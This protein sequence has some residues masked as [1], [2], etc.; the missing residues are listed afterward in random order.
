MVQPG[1]GSALDTPRTNI[2]DATYLNRQ[3]D[4]ADISQEASF[5]SP[6]KDG[7]LLQQLRNGRSTGISL[8]TPRQRGPLADRRNLPPSI[9]GAEFTPLLKSATRNSIQKQGK[10][11]GA[12]MSDTP[13]LSKIDEDDVTALPRMDGS[14]YSVSRNQSYLDNTLPHVES[15]SVASTPL[16]MQPRR[17]ANKGPLQ[18]GNQLSLREQENVIDRIEKEN[19][20]LKLKIHFLEEAL[21]KAGPGFSEA[22]LKENTELK[23]DKVTMQRE[24]Q[25]YKKHVSTAEKD[26]ET[27]RQE[28]LELQEKTKRR[29]TDETQRLKLEQLQKALEEREANIDNLQR[30]LDQGRNDDDQLERLRDK[31]EDMEADLREKDRQITERDDELDEVRERVV[32][33]EDEAKEAQRRLA[34]LNEMEQQ[35]EELE[36]AKETIQDLQ[37]TLRQLE[38]QIAEVKDTADNAISQRDRAERDLEELQEE[39]A[40]KSVVTKGLSRQIEEKVARLQE[41]LDRSGQEYADVE[42]ELSRANEENERLRAELDETKNGQDEA[43]RGQRLNM[44]RIRELE[45]ELLAVADEKDTL[46]LRHES[47]M[48]ESD[49]LQHEVQ[50]LEG[51]V[52][53]LQ[54]HTADEKEYALE[55]EKDLRQQFEDELERLNNEIS[56]LQAEVRER[57]NLYDNDSEK[58]DVERQTLVSDRERAEERAAGLQRTIDRLRE[59]EGSLSSKE[60]SLQKAM[61]SEMERHKSE[62]AVTARQ[63][64]DLQDALETRASLL[65]KLRNELSTARDELRQVQID[66]QAQVNKVVAMEDEIELLRLKTSAQG[67]PGRMSSAVKESQ[68]LQDQVKKLKADLAS[69]QNS[70]AEA[71]AKCDELQG[72]LRQQ[73]CP[74]NDGLQMDQERLDLRAAKMKLDNEVRRLTDE[75][76]SLK[77]SLAATEKALDDARDNACATEQSLRREIGQLQSKA[78]SVSP[79]KSN[80]QGPLAAHHQRTIRE[81]EQEVGFYRDELSK[82]QSAGADEDDAA[83]NVSSLRRD[84]ATLRQKE[85]DFLQRESSQRSLVKQLE[86]QVA[87]LERQLHESRVSRLA[88]SPAGSAAAPSSRQVA[89]LQQE[90]SDAQQALDG[91]K[92]QSTEAERRASKTLEEL[93][94]QLNDLEDQKL[95]LEEVLEEAREQA[96][97]LAAHNDK[98]MRRLRHKLD[99]AERERDAAVAS[100][101]GE[102]G[103]QLR[104]SQAEM[105]S[106][107]SSVRQQ[108]ELIDGLAAAEAVLRRKLEKARSERAAFRMSAEKLRRDMQ[109]LQ[110]SGSAAESSDKHALETLVRAAES[111]QGQHKKEVKGMVMQMEWMQARWEREALLRSD[112]AFAKGFVQ[113]QLDVANACNKAQLRELEHIRTHLLQSK[114]P[115]AVSLPANNNNNNNN[116]AAS[117]TAAKP[118]SIRPFL[119]MAR[120]IARMRVSSRRWAEQEHVRLKLVAARDEQRRVKRS[121]QFKIVRMES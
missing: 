33:A 77:E 83:T 114:K 8:R 34:E 39:M 25:R 107:G 11:N 80:S 81:L 82:L 27:Y 121:K 6:G 14:M 118:S 28:M 5:Q 54:K 92:T 43:Q 67:T 105:S 61:E 51:E 10:E 1:L 115:L 90:L 21:R 59:A 108:Q 9:G 93:Q 99:R 72:R 112:A 41:E 53:E 102:Q 100:Q 31:V 65:T 109:L 3:P 68:A 36:E 69:T 116:K 44:A 57:D 88:R 50:R 104:Q 95:V 56:N 64:D 40:N 45:T 79:T 47:L 20:G 62:E 78:R 110:K 55:I 71:R 7:D 16:V 4:F 63:I 23:V 48:V 13:G 94:C 106:L 87:D 73:G 17:G 111:A 89:A 30:L 96:E 38:Q 46:Q 22:A 75:K 119:A 103:R 15:S 101:S 29:Q 66:Y 26:L 49:A 18:D 76:R 35:T 70:L 24:L 84:L 19:F 2:G 85:L 60:A 37:T 42:K 113:L 98:A 120:F 52:E 117:G 91:L 86:A 97:E 32:A 12:A 58:W 74:E